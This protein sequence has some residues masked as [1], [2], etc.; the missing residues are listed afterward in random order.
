M[1]RPA[2][3]LGLSSSKFK[4]W[5]SLFTLKFLFGHSLFSSILLFLL[6]LFRISIEVDIG[7]DLLWL[8]TGGGTVQAQNYPGQHPP[9]QIH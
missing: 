3:D 9:H 2:C 4:S 7:H 1:C 5:K 8:L 6:N